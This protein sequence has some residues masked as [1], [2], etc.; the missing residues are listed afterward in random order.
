MLGWLNHLG[1]DIVLLQ[2]MWP[3]KQSWNILEFLSNEFHSVEKNALK[4]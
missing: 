2:Q 1:V 3:I 4:K